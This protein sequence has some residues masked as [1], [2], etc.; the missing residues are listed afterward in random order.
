MENPGK[1]YRRLRAWELGMELTEAVY[2]TVRN[3]PS[4]ERLGLISQM[5]RAAASVPMNL[6]EGYGRG[7]KEFVRFIGIAYGSLLE[8]ETQVELASRLG[9]IDAVETHALEERTAEL[10]KVL[11]GLRRALVA[12]RARSEVREEPA[13]YS[14]WPGALTSLP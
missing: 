9:F 11:N 6:A 12:S 8:L 10:G 5:K 14:L 4:E 2:Q 13:S 7:G 1:G 3:F